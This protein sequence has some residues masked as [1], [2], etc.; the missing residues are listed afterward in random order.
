MGEYDIRLEEFLC[1]HKPGGPSPE[2][3]MSSLS[4]IYEHERDIG[5]RSFQLVICACRFIPALHGFGR[6][7]RIA[8]AFTSLV[9]HICFSRLNFLLALFTATTIRI[10]TLTRHKS[11]DNGY[12][13]EEGCQPPSFASTKEVPI[14]VS[15]D[16]SHILLGR[17]C[18]DFVLVARP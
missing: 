2:H 18:A 12:K 8:L 14:R 15:S 6:L 4:L 11:H 5:F 10:T 16:R 3:G 7:P 13:Q 9:P 1:Y 17:P